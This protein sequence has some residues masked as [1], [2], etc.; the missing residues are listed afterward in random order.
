MGTLLSIRVVSVPSSNAEGT[1]IHRGCFSSR[2]FVLVSDT[3][4]LPGDIK[5][6]LIAKKLHDF[7]QIF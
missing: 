7:T 3:H 4:P 2:F 1:Q 5:T 6:D